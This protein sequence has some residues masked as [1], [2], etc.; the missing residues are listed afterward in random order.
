MATVQSAVNLLQE[1]DDTTRSLVDACMTQGAG[2]PVAQG[3]HA[4]RMVLRE[5]IVDLLWA[6]MQLAES[7]IV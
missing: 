6:G 1:Y 5:E 3:L 7:D 2:S 4:R